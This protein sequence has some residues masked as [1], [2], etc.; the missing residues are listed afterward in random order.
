MA[1]GYDPSAAARTP[2]RVAAIKG[3]SLQSPVDIALFGV[4][5]AA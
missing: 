5:E 4:N 2:F 3:S 1:Q